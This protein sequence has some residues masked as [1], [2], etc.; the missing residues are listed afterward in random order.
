MAKRKLSAEAEPAV[1]ARTSKKRKAAEDSLTKIRAIAEAEGTDPVV[2]FADEKTK[3]V[4]DVA[5]DHA[6]EEIPRVVAPGFRLW[7][8]SS[9]MTAGGDLTAISK[10]ITCQHILKALLISYSMM[11]RPGTIRIS[12]MF[13]PLRRSGSYP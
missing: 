6:D 12:S 9:M 2:E 8:T 4:V 13:N 1:P 5:E 11:L 10:V 7:N 3:T